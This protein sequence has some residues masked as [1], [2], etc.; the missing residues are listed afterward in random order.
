MFFF[1][2]YFSTEEKKDGLRRAVDGRRPDAGQLPRAAD[3]EA[4]HAGD[5]PDPAAVRRALGPGE[6]APAGRGDERRRS[7]TARS[8]RSSS[9]ASASRP[10]RT[11]QLESHVD[12]DILG[13]IVLRVGNSILDASI[14][15]RLDQLDEKWRR[16]PNATTGR[17]MQIK[18]DEITN[19]LKSRIEG[20]DVA[21]ADLAEV[22]TVLS[23]A[24]GIAR[25]H[26]LENCMSFEMLEFPHDVT[27]PRA[28]PR[29][30]QRRRRAVRRVGEGRR[31]RH[32]QA[33]R[34]PARHPRRRGAARP[35]RRPARQAA[36]RQGRDRD[37]RD[38]PG[39]VQG[40]R[41]RP[42]PAGDGAGA[43]RA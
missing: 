37:D 12:P 42:A 28:E 8:C 20:L 39:G 3:R 17:D 10:A 18:P 25:V 4:P 23:V 5:V 24:D 30:R 14:R 38:A 40:A 21:G 13:G 35:D 33:H 26:G 16:P 29:V 19:I 32:R 9:G 41:R 7:S 15:H 27:G 31:G 22:G 11:S 6:Q 2:P 36:R 1:S 34:P 43:D